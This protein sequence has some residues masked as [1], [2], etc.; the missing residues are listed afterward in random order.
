MQEYPD[1]TGSKMLDALILFIAVIIIAKTVDLIISK[2]LKR[3][4]SRTATSIDDKIIDILH[5]PIFLVILL[6]GFAE[7]LRYLKLPAQVL[8]Y[9][10][11][12]AHSM[13]VVL[14]GTAGVRL[15]N[16]MTQHG[17]QKISDITGL[18]K[19][20]IPFLEN[21]W[22]I[23]IFAVGLIFVLSIWRINLTP[24][25]AS[26]G[27]AGVAVAL[28]AKDTLANF[29]GGISI[30]MDRAYKIGD[31]IVLE[32][33][34]R[35]AVVTIG[36]RSTRIK[37]RD[38][39]MITVP[40]S[41]LATTKIINESAPEPRFR[42]KIPIGIAYGSDIELVERVLLGIAHDNGN[43]LEEPG[44]RVRFRQFADSSLN[45][46][47]LCW[48][49]EPAVR[50]LAVHEINV[51]IDKQFR[52]NSILIPFPQRDVHIIGPA[53]ELPSETDKV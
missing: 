35:G 13:L 12:I 8:F 53:R 45:F 1:I 22:K 9:S 14:L 47:L 50:G 6:L 30:F 39:I 34:E 7:T 11:G 2:I 18:G 52:Q 46:E 31:Y 42:V 41:I 24:V 17:L 20:V 48:V 5:Q 29:F 43:V 32:S 33:G 37:T 26:A 28:A 3:I 49:T 15:T 38:D 51:E 44:P 23:V 16:L 10:D 25:L 19:D 21:V 27:I 36:L 40:N 4:A